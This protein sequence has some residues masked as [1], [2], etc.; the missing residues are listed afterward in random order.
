MTQKFSTQS[1]KSIVK[2]LTT[3][4]GVSL[5]ATAPTQE[6]TSAQKSASLS[7]TRKFSISTSM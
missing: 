3:A 2:V 1:T 7:L 6:V 4:C 5:T